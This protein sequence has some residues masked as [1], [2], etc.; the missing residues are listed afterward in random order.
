M[1][2]LL[3]VYSLKTAHPIVYVIKTINSNSETVRIQVIKNLRIYTCT[4]SKLG[5]FLLRCYRISGF[6]PR[7]SIF[8]YVRMSIKIVKI[9]SRKFDTI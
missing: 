4:S 7:A 5:P 3:T 1:Y 6:L 8:H 2:Y 9:Q